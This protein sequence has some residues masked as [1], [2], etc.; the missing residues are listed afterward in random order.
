[1]NQ[2][3]WKR[4]LYVCC[5]GSFINIVAM[6]LLLPFLPLYVEQ[7]GVTDRGAIV[8]WSGIAY[9]ATFFAAALV[10]PLWGRVAD[11]YGCKPNLIRASA[12]MAVSMCLIGLAQNV[13]QLVALRLLVGLAG[14]YTSGSFVLVA[15]QTP[16]QHAGWA[17]GVL[18]SAIMAGGLV[19]P[20]AGGLLPGLVGIQPT[21]MLAGACILLN[22]GA[23]CLFIRETPVPPKTTP[24]APTPAGLWASVRA[25]RLVIAMFVTAALLMVAN[26]SIEPIITIYIQQLLRQQDQV[27]LVAGVTMSAT[28][29]GS[30]LS[31]AHLGKLADRIGGLNVVVL[32]LASA[33][34]L[35]VPQAFVEQA[36][37]LVL[38]RFL[39]GVS[40]GG[41]L[42]AVTTL[43]RHSV[44]SRVVG[45]VLGYSTA[46]QYLG[47]VVGPLMGGFIGAHVGMRAVFLVTSVL[48]F[49]AA[50]CNWLLSAA[51]ATPAARR[52]E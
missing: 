25:P 7:L 29:L 19:G 24:G 11:R 17:L 14:G 51:I 20:L 49:G 21:F 27:T 31:A 43:I 12:G 4:N 35:L 22:L 9:G 1:V 36:W 10:A 13:A 34:V 33:A 41:L 39:M 5:F 16:K 45:R 30:V 52:S 23:T 26:M 37:Q 2:L 38:L 28:A 8:Q 50:V 6:T 48:L 32:C 46:A 3:N 18:S 40:L 44:P 15:G 42:P 47:Q